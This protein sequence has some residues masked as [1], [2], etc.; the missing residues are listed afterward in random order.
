MR[1]KLLAAGVAMMTT[2]VLA[3]SANAQLLTRTKLYI[4]SLN[5]NVGRGAG[6]IFG[7]SKDLSCVFVT[8]NGASE[9]YQGSIRKFG[10]NVGFTKAAHVLWHVYSFGTD[11]G[12]GALNGQ[13]AGGQE[14]L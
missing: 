1:S 3:A 5:C 10:I 4:G 13:Y 14:S 8:N 2:S 11:G 9:L 6:L 7:S 12:A